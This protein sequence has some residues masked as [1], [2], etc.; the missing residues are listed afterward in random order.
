MKPDQEKPEVYYWQAGGRVTVAA[1]TR[2]R[3]PGP[4]P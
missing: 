2:I 3:E 4:N 1:V